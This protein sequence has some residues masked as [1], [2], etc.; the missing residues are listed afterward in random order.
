MKIHRFLGDFDL[1]DKIIKTQ[2]RELINQFKNVLRLGVGDSVILLDGSGRKARAR[3]TNLSKDLIEFSLEEVINLSNEPKREVILYCAILKK[4][5]F[6]LVVQK[7]VEIGVKEIVPIITK[8]TIKTG[9]NY[10][11]LNKIIKEAVEQSGRGIVPVLHNTTEFEEI[12]KKESQDNLLRI[13]CDISGEFWPSISANIDN[14]KIAV[15]VG[16]EGGW[17]SSEI[18][19]AKNSGFKIAKLGD[20]TLRG[21]TAAIIASYLACHSINN[22]S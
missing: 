1:S 5:N 10:E 14:K 17:E 4:E 21:E 16:P 20:F 18:E 22:Y 3:V 19:I 11:R 12:I 9:L 7:A 8:R 2:N 15:F 13:I 6:E